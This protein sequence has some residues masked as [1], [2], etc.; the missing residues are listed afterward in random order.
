M[1][2]HNEKYQL[3]FDIENDVSYIEKELVRC[4]SWRKAVQNMA[5]LKGMKKCY[6]LPPDLNLMNKCYNTK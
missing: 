2:T 5:S 6:L 3:A 1:R 4:Q